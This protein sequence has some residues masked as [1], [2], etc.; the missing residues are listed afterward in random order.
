VLK[1]CDRTVE[2]TVNDGDV[3]HL[4]ESLITTFVTEISVNKLTVYT[5]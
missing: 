3:I 5:C 1:D 2:H 4:K